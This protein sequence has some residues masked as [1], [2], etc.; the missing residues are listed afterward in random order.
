MTTTLQVSKEKLKKPPLQIQTLGNRVLRQPSKNVASINEEIRLLAQQML[1]TMYSADGIGLAAPQVGVN[2]RLIVVDLEPDKAEHPPLVLIN[3][4]VK[5]VSNEISLDQEGCLSVPNVYADVRRP[6]KITV[7]YRD[8]N[9]KPMS[10]EASGLLARCILHEID[11]LDGVMFV[12]LVENQLDL[13]PKLVS[14]GFSM[15]DVQSRI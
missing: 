1:Q 2:K 8:L 4:A 3:P 6:T 11:H 5:K 9:G 7:T 14:K 10:L 15:K 12:D 13:T